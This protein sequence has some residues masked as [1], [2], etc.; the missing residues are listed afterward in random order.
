MAPVLRL[1]CD[2]RTMRLVGVLYVVR[3]IP[4]HDRDVV[5]YG[6]GGVALLVLGGLLIAYANRRKR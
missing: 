5:L 3:S 6:I 4:T 2:H 1:S